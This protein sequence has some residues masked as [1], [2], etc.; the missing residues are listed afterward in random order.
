MH[1]AQQGTNGACEGCHSSIKGGGLAQKRHLIG[2]RT[3]WL[4]RKL[5]FEV[6]LLTDYARNAGHFYLYSRAHAFRIHLLLVAAL[7]QSCYA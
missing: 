4:L 5:L 3:D 6:R 7:L 1:H 2:R